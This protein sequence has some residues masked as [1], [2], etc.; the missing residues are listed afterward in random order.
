MPIPF[1]CSLKKKMKL[2][3]KR[4]SYFPTHT[5]L[6]N[7]NSSPPTPTPTPCFS[8]CFF[9][10]IFNDHP[11]CYIRST[12]FQENLTCKVTTWIMQQRENSTPGLGFSFFSFR[13]PYGSWH[14]IHNPLIS[15][16]ADKLI[17]VHD[18][19][20]KSQT[21]KCWLVL[22]LTFCI[23]RFFEQLYMKKRR[24]NGFRVSRAFLGMKYTQLK[25]SVPCCLD[26]HGHHSKRSYILP[27]FSW[28]V[29]YQDH[30]L[31]WMNPNSSSFFW[32]EDSLRF[33][34]LGFRNVSSLKTIWTSHAASDP[35][36]PIGWSL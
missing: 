26:V 34:P 31:M 1:Y 4:F 24:A 12:S 16:L 18:W 13:N 28:K 20:E 30:P 10:I 35:S 25:L 17:Q 15:T 36:G 32:L 14:L 11:R 33:V 9:W 5:K 7:P 23:T 3:L 22:H 6:R 27:S 29:F 19:S 21:A 8:P 2:T